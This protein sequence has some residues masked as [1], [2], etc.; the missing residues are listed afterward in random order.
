MFILP[1]TKIF[2]KKIM[3]C[4]KF[5]GHRFDVKSIQESESFGLI[6][7]VKNKSVGVRAMFG[8]QKRDKGGS[9]VHNI[10]RHTKYKNYNKEYIK[11]TKARTKNLRN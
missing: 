2:M 9:N 5:S 3:W 8:N 6:E 4:L 10:N 7:T 1:K 11:H